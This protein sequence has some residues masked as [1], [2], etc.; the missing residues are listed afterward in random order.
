MFLGNC[1][2]KKFPKKRKVIVPARG[3]IYDR[4]KNKIVSNI[5]YYN[6][7]FVEKNILDFDTSSFAKLVNM[8]VEEVKNRFLEIKKNKEV[9]ITKTQ[10]RTSNYL[11]VKSLSFF[12]RNYSFRNGCYC[13]I[14]K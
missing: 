4:N 9:I 12:K 6:L 2:L 14:L 5:T 8:S 10:K 1:V 11:K 7:M 3:I 13:S